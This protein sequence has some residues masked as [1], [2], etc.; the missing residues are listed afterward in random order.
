[1]RHR[2]GLAP[3][4]FACPTTTSGTHRCFPPVQT[5]H[6][7]GVE[8]RS[9]IGGAKWMIA[10]CAN[11]VRRPPPRSSGVVPARN[12]AAR[13]ARL[14]RW[15]VSCAFAA[16]TSGLGTCNGPPEAHSWGAARRYRPSR[17]GGDRLAKR[18]PASKAVQRFV[19][20]AASVITFS[21]SRD[22]RSSISAAR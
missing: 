22:M 12:K 8:S 20:A 3:N 5:P 17:L 19:Q 9:R 6:H 21:S 15:A 2:H 10:E 11:S 16:C 4:K 7:Q 18:T 1:M 13:N 14:T